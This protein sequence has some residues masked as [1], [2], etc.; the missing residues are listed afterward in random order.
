MVTRRWGVT[1]WSC[2]HAGCIPRDRGSGLCLLFDETDPLRVTMYLALVGFATDL[3]IG[4]VWAYAQDVGGRNCGAVM[5]WA[6]MWGN[7]GAAS[8]PFSWGY[9]RAVH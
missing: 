6:N 1:V 7:L 5:G 8:R 3:G 2:H 9:S 4:A